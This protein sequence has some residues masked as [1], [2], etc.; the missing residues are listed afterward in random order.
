MSA[1]SDYI[2]YH[3]NY[4]VVDQ[5]KESTPEA[6][7][8]YLANMYSQNK[9]RMQYMTS[10]QFF[11]T[12]LETMYKVGLTAADKKGEEEFFNLLSDL[13]SNILPQA[14]AEMVQK[15][16]M[17]DVSI[18]QIRAAIGDIEKTQALFDRFKVVVEQLTGSTFSK[19]PIPV[20]TM[21]LVESTEGKD[22]AQKIRRAYRD[23]YLKNGTTFKIDDTYKGALKSHAGQ[24]NTILANMSAIESILGGGIKK[25][26]SK[27]KSACLSGL[28][29][30]T[31]KM[32][33]TVIGFVSEDIIEEAMEPYLAEYLKKSGIKDVKIS[34]EGGTKGSSIYNK[35]TEDISMNLNLEQMLDG[36]IG[37]ID[38]T[39]P[40]VSLKRTNIVANQKFA[41]IHIKNRTVL[42]KML[43]MSDMSV[44]LQQFY[45]AYATYNMSIKDRKNSRAQLNRSASD[46]MEQ[47][48]DYV[49]AAILPTSL[50]GSLHA[51]DFSTF[52][53]IND[54]VYNIVDMIQKLAEDDNYG[55]I[56]SDLSEKQT[57]VKNRHNE[58]FDGYPHPWQRW[59]RSADI[60]EVIR[61]LGIT[62]QLNINLAKAGM[63]IK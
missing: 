8:E 26:D 16:E 49:H 37:T 33:N 51:G 7:A 14:A 61:N 54:K 44:P 35:K 58:I 36:E 47:M 56:T 3:Y 6:N 20:L 23:A 17:P 18:P 19:N 40:G 60:K 46:A 5:P 43:D 29:L 25:Y 39:L 13:E 45:Q 62:V 12:K 41:K 63:K 38:I 27:I 30:G 21:P 34:T 32:L 15:L 55:Y 57:G 2:H 48:Y 9:V 1:V 10:L 52:I 24:V 22:T 53:I 4:Q 59:N 11:K 42:G 31:F 28:F 50:A